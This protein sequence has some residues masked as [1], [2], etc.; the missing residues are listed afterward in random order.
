MP[1]FG[2][3]VPYDRSALELMRRLLRHTQRQGRHFGLEVRYRKRPVWEDLVVV[4]G[5]LRGMQAL[6]TRLWIELP[7]LT[8]WH[9]APKPTWRRS[10]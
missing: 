2:F 1:G 5:P 8:E 4:D 9:D 3:T 7:L 6:S 10:R